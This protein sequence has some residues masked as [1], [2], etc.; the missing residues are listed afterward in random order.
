MN[1]EI[2]SVNERLEDQAQRLSALIGATKP[3]ATD[4]FF[5]VLGRTGSGKST[6]ISRCT[7]K[8]TNISHG[9]FSC[10]D[11]L[12][13]FD[14][15]WEGRHI[16]L[17]D[18]PGFNDTNRSEIDTLS[19]LATYLGA[20]YSNGVRISGLLLLH[21]IS[22]NRV[23]GTN[24]RT[25]EMVEAMCGFDR[26]DNLAI[27][28]TMWP[29]H[30]TK[31]ERATLNAR[32][33]ELA[34]SDKFYGSMISKG[35]VMFRHHGTDR[36]GYNGEASSEKRILAHLIRRSDL[37][38][39]EVLRLQK[40]L[41]DE[42]KTIGETSAGAIVAA[43][44]YRHRQVR[45]SA[46]QQLE[47]RIREHIYG[48]SKSHLVELRQTKAAWQQELEKSEESKE[49][50]RQ[51][52]ADLGEKEFQRAKQKIDEI[53]D[54]LMGQ[55]NL[56]E[57]DLKDMEDSL[58]HINNS[59]A[60]AL[61]LPKAPEVGDGS[62][63][64]GQNQASRRRTPSP[65]PSATP[66]ASPSTIERHLL[67]QN[68]ELMKLVRIA[69]RDASEMRRI[70]AAFKGKTRDQALNGT[71]NGVAAGAMSGIIAAVAAGGLLCS[72]M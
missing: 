32:E 20:S 24:L 66:S 1:P 9:L 19:V 18:T 33:A 62:G 57:E 27:A 68:E 34:G 22:D 58:H 10:T 12:D 49:T 52:M 40:E 42:K 31:Y 23:S 15:R 46:L 45:E 55:V 64:N 50:L 35:A 69:R 38:A 16:Y 61:A 47:E 53:E 25:I 67:S 4:R 72:V 54:H 30:S 70:Y 17:I 59:R 7:G 48:G 21:P 56:K 13:V 44:V 6:F 65:T 36:K 8:D 51:S 26:Y 41:I 71:V 11:S 43:D 29:E 28:T 63:S 60:M 39:P 2:E 37:H 5:L 3:R 14:M